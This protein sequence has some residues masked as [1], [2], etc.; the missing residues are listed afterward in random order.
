MG[1]HRGIV[2]RR[3]PRPT[4]S[5]P[6]AHIQGRMVWVTAQAGR[7]PRTGELVPGGIDGQ[8]NQAI[9]NL[10]AILD[11]CGSSLER[12]VK[13]QIMYT[14]AADEDVIDAVYARRFRAPFPARTTWGVIFLAAEPG[15][16]VVRVQIDCLAGLG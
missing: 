4:G 12:V 1:S 15:T 7:D 16:E 11:E 5:Y 14:D 10:A 2:S 8:L 6:H 9:D 13:T 3:G